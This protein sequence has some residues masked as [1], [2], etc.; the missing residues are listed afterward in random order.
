MPIPVVAA[1]SGS[2]LTAA[3]VTAVTS[4]KGQLSNVRQRQQ[5]H[6]RRPLPDGHAWQLI[7]LASQAG[8][9]QNQITDLVDSLRATIAHAGLPAGLQAHLA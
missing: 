8:G 3:D 2:P 9:S 1:R 7:V 6:R 4:L 5:G